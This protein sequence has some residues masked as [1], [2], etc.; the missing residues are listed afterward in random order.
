[1]YYKNVIC[2][3]DLIRRQCYII[4]VENK[5]EIVEQYIYWSDG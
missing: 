1:M 5:F 4:L 2:Y 3:S